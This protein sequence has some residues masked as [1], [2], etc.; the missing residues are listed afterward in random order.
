MGFSDILTTNYSYE[1]EIAASGR[2]NIS[3]WQLKEGRTHTKTVR[4][5]EGKYY[6]H[7]YQEVSY[8]QIENRIWHIHGEARCPSS[9][10]IGHYQYGNLFSRIREYLKQAGNKYVEE[11]KAQELT[12]TDAA[13]ISSWIDAFILGDVH[14]LG[15][16]YN[17]SE[18]DLWWLLDRKMREKAQKGTTHFYYYDEETKTADVRD[19]LNLLQC[20]GV[21][22]HAVPESNRKFFY[23]RALEVIHQQM[24]KIHNRS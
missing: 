4:R 8:K 19:K 17:V 14:I 5:A 6:L 23:D 9:I 7:T 21:T 10:V 22:L 1:L 11:Q 20:Y 13:Y 12:G 2:E 15:F 24:Q 3:K 18:F 16:G